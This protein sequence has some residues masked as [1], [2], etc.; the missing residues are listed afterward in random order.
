[1]VIVRGPVQETRKLG[2]CP[3]C[4]ERH[5]PGNTSEDMLTFDQPLPQSCIRFAATVR[6]Q[7]PLDA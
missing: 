5:D 6:G 1:M 7:T 3:Y 2:G 4:G